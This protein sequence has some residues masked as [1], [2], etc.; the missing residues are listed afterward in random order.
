MYTWLSYN[1]VIISESHGNVSDDYEMLILAN[2]QYFI[3]VTCVIV[4]R[5]HKIERLI[6]HKYNLVF[7]IILLAFST[8]KFVPIVS[9]NLISSLYI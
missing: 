5:F 6:P 9:C 4:R 7:F 3:D 2:V 1:N 8:M